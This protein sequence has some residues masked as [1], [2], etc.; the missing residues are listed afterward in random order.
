MRLEEKIKKLRQQARL[1]GKTRKTERNEKTPKDIYREVWQYNGKNKK[2]QK[3]LAKKGRLKRHWGRIK[4]NKY[5]KP[6][7]RYEINVFNQ[8]S[9]ECTIQ[10]PVKKK[11]KKK[12]GVK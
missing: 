8:V 4:Q 12:Y 3:I 11:K 10:L 5:N 2:V 1:L 7:L 6:F 9:G